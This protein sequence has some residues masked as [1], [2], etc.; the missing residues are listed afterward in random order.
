MRQ[1]LLRPVEGMG[2]VKCVPARAAA[3]RRPFSKIHRRLR[4]GLLDVF[5]LQLYGMQNKKYIFVSILSKSQKT[6]FKK[7]HLRKYDIL[8]ICCKIDVLV[9]V[10]RQQI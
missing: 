8:S 3:G 2:P 7:Y 1:L 9:N 10:P 4:Q 6:L 5:F